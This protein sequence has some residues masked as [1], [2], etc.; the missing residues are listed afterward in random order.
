MNSAFGKY[1]LLY[2]T[3]IYSVVNC[4]EI[5]AFYIITIQ[6]QKYNNKKEEVIINCYN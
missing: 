5:I 4:D 6:R 3:T 2:N 1:F